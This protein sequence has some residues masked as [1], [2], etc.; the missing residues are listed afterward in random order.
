MAD[1]TAGSQTTLLNT[2]T[3]PEMTDLVRREWIWTQQH[4]A[5]NAE[6]LFI[7]QPVGAGQGST[8]RFN[9][10]DV[11]TYADFK[12]EGTDSQKS[13]IGVGYSLDMTARTFSKEIE[14]TLEMRNDN[15]YAEV[16]AL[17]TSLT[18]FCE[19]RK[20]LDLTHR[21][22]FATST[23]YTDMNGETVN[24]E[25][26]DGLALLS[27]V[28]T[29][30]FSSTTFRNRVSADPVFSQGSYESAL[31]LAATET[32]NN[33]GHKRTLNYNTIV[34]GDDPSTVRAIRQLLESS[35][36][37]DAQHA[38]IAN[39]YGGTKRHVILP[40]LATDANGAYDSTKRRWWFVVAA[41]QGMNGWQA[42]V[43]E[44]IA[45]SIKYPSSGNN[46]EDIHSLNWYYMT[47]CR[48]GICIPTPKGCIGSPVSS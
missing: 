30:A 29:L 18:E 8:K 35:A 48:Y 41:G 17:I 2:L 47:Y 39:V 3:L 36:D 15:R 11:E 9:E 26:G 24:V 46:A 32:Y 1:G 37:V 12:A 7:K 25:V 6:Q 40:N 21:F 27:A 22:T 16:G 28:H 23:S 31:L 5:R 14:I 38:G 19:N 42:Y 20:D 4:I 45:P 44:W 13:R 34:S 43:G 33:F 10:V